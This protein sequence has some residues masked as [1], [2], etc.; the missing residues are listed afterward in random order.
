MLKKKPSTA[1]IFLV[2]FA[3]FITSLFLSKSP[4]TSWVNIALVEVFLCLPFCLAAAF[5]TVQE[6]SV[7]S[8]AMLY[9][10]I[11]AAFEAGFLAFPINCGMLN[12][13]LLGVVMVPL[14]LGARPV[15]YVFGAA[16]AYTIVRYV[17]PNVGLILRLILAMGFLAVVG[18]AT[19]YSTYV[20]PHSYVMAKCP[21]L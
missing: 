21:D 15:Q 10:S 3:L 9:L 4:G 12:N 5:E 13:V 14:A 6:K 11:G 2:G 7:I 16:L 8:P 17:F 19:A 18:V 20:H 1:T